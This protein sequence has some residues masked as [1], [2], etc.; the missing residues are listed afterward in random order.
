MFSAS[1]ESVRTRA[2][3]R[4]F[5]REK[6]DGSWMPGAR[7]GS[8]GTSRVRP[9]SRMASTPSLYAASRSACVATRSRISAGIFALSESSTES[10]TRRVSGDDALN[11][12]GA[13]TGPIA[14]LP[15]LRADP[16]GG[17]TAANRGGTIAVG[18]DPN[19]A[20]SAARGVTAL[21][22][23]RAD[24]R[25]GSTPS[26]AA[27]NSDVGPAGSAGT[28]Y[29]TRSTPVD[30]SLCGAASRRGD[31]VAKS[32]A[33]SIAVTTSAVASAA[34]GITGAGTAI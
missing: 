30:M 23:A 3:F 8:A 22:G 32:N 26:G 4:C 14:E 29:S 13:R 27:R 15:P 18:A 10:M 33:S 34:R 16:P 2:A 19:G 25:E 20:A 7:W 9:E 24:S 5:R 31:N 12:R 17:A 1:T 11:P 28:T 21:I 6:N